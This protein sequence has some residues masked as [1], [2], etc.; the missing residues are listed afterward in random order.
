M[1]DPIKHRLMVRPVPTR[2][3]SGVRAIHFFAI[4][5]M[6][7]TPMSAEE[8]LPDIPE[9]PAVWTAADYALHSPETFRQHAPVKEVIR[10]ETINHGLLAAA[11]FFATNE[12]RA[13]RKLPPLLH[14]PALHRAAQTHTHDMAIAGFFAHDNPRDP[15]RRTPWQRMAAEG[16]DG[17][18]RS[19]NIAKTYVNKLTYLSAADAIVAMWMKSPGH[20]RN[21]LDPRVRFLGC[22]VHACRCPQFHLLATQNFASEA[23]H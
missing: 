3:R 11:V 12:Q 9:N 2:L 5:T 7:A 18:F 8:R 19:E 1:N 15:A 21:L 14:S 22:G 13:S 10:R 17:G 6:L 4:L 20:R 23:A 16:V